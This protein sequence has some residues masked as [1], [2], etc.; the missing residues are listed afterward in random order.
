MAESSEEVRDRH[1]AWP[2]VP[3]PLSA[4]WQA[5]EASNGRQDQ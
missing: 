4:Q 1:G 5:A 2:K 3:G